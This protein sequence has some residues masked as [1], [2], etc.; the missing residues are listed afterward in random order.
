MFN[1]LSSSNCLLAKRV[2][3]CVNTAFYV[4]KEKN[5]EKISFTIVFLSDLGKETWTFSKKI[6]AGCQNHNLRVH[7][8]NLRAK[9]L[10]VRSKTF[11]CVDYWWTIW[12]K[13]KRTYSGCQNCEKPPEEHYGKKSLRKEIGYYFVSCRN[14]SQLLFLLFREMFAIVVKTSICVLLED[15]EENQFF[16][17]I[18]QGFKPL[19]T[20]SQK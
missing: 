5:E 20:L 8:N 15:F 13:A 19:R 1:D 2:I 3:R 12:A 7:K 9:F 6:L 4:Y 10:I 14:L 18:A 17:K 16:F 11:H